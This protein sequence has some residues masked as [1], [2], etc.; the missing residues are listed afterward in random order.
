MENLHFLLTL[1]FKGYERK[2]VNLI[3]N[4]IIV[5]IANTLFINEIILLY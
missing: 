1:S 5:I 4:L 3:S 2:K